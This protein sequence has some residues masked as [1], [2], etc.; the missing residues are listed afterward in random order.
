MTDPLAPA[1]LDEWER[2]ARELVDA[3]ARFR[4]D[5]RFATAQAEHAARR[6]FINVLSP[7]RILGLIAAVRAGQ[8]QEQNRL[9]ETEKNQR[10]HHRSRDADVRAFVQSLAAKPCRG[11]YRGGNWA[12]DNCIGL[13]AHATEHP[14]HYGDPLLTEFR[15]GAHLCETCRARDVLTAAAPEER[16]DA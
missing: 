6:A 13:R 7:E 2:L 3:K 16:D 12:S 8:E 9:A 1:A 10:Q 11:G 15:T 5:S 14:E 4:D